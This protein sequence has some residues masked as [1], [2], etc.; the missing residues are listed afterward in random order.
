MPSSCAVFGLNT[1]K[2]GVNRHLRF[3]QFPKN[4]EMYRVWVRINNLTMASTQNISELKYVPTHGTFPSFWEMDKAAGA[5]S[6]QIYDYLS[7]I[8]LKT[9]AFLLMVRH[10]TKDR[11]YLTGSDVIECSFFCRIAESSQ[12][13]IIVQTML[14]TIY[15]YP[16]IIFCVI[17]YLLN[18]Y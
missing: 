4:S 2:S 16:H 7:Q 6:L 15:I 8:Q 18:I 13:S 1:S 12:P 9:K 17:V 10:N 3:C 14:Y 5:Y 11:Q